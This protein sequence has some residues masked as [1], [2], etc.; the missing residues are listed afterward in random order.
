MQNRE[1]VG[2]PHHTTTH[3]RRARRSRAAWG[4]WAIAP[5]VAVVAALVGAVMVG[6]GAQPATAQ[7]P[8]ATGAFAVDGV[9]SSV[10]FRAQRSIGA[11]FYGRFNKLDGSFLIDEANL[12]TSFIDVTIP[13]DSVDSNNQNRDRHL[14][15]ADFFSAEEFPTLSFKSKSVAKTGDKTFAVTGDLT[16]RG[17]TKEIVVTAKQTGTGDARGGGTAI[18]YDVAFSFKRADFGMTYMPDALADEIQIM[19]GLEGV[20]K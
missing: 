5:G 3:A 15:S 20:R 1:I 4:T 18:G 13:A 12:S 2:G 9:H 14:K 17:K 8:A 6:G 7:A 10:I 19:V 16:F 11:P